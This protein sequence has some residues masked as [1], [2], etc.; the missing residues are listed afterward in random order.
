MLLSPSDRPQNTAQSQGGPAPRKD[1]D[2][3]TGHQNREQQPYRGPAGHN[4]FP[5]ALPECVQRVNE[6]LKK[7]QNCQIWTSPGT[8]GAAVRL[9]EWV[10]GWGDSKHQNR[11]VQM[12]RDHF[13]RM[14]IPQ[15][16][17]G[18]LLSRPWVLIKP[19]P[20]HIPCWKS[21]RH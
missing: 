4:K 19:S 20:P 16:S 17:M 3:G 5:F 13:L 12:V 7:P 6:W 14:E 10:L 15:Q 11:P 8:P 18:L 1:R 9:G 21:S 2:T